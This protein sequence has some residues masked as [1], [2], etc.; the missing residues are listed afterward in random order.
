MNII[1]I[2]I[3]NAQKECW[4]ACSEK[5]KSCKKTGRIS[6]YKIQ[7]LTAIS[8]ISTPT[9]FA[10]PSGGSVVSGTGNIQV[11]DNGKQIS[12]NQNSD[13]IIINWDSFGIRANEKVTFNQPSSNSAAL[14][15]IQGI[16]GSVIM[17]Q[18][19]SNGKVFLINPN[20][21]LFGNGSQVNVGGLTASTQ[22]IT[23][24]DFNNGNNRFS[25]NSRSTIM[26]QGTINS[27]NGSVVLLANQIRN[28]GIINTAN[29]SIV[30]GAGNSFIVN[31]D[32]AGLINIKVDNG[33]IDAL[34][35]N[36]NKLSANGGQVYIAAR[37][38]TNLMKTV[39]NNSGSIEANT[40]N[41][42]AG[43]IVLDAG[44]KDRADVNGVLS[45]SAQG[46]N[47]GN[48]G[49][50][51]ISGK[52]VRVG[53]GAQLNT[54]ANNGITG[55]VTIKADDFEVTASGDT[56]PR[57]D[58]YIAADT[59]SRNLAYSNVS[60][61]NTNSNLAINGPVS[62]TSKNKLELNTPADILINDNIT[63]TGVNSSLALNPESGN[64]TLA[65]GKKITLSG[66]G[67]GFSVK[68]RIY[69]IIQTVDQ[70]QR[71]NSNLYGLYV[72]G[73]N[74]DG[75]NR[76]FESI[77][78]GSNPYSRFEGIL[79]GFGNTITRL[80]IKSTGPN[81][82]LFSSNNGIIKNINL[83]QSTIS[84][85]PSQLT[86]AVGS[87]IGYNTGSLINSSSSISVSASTTSG[88]VNSIGGLVG[89][90]SG[91][92]DRS[93]NSGAVY[94]NTNTR[95]VGGIAGENNSGTI[96]NS[97]NTGSITGS[98]NNNASSSNGAGGLV[99]TNYLGIIDNSQSSG[100]V[101]VY[102]SSNSGGLVGISLGSLI[103]NSSSKGTVRSG[104]YYYYNS[105]INNA[106]GLVGS[107]SDGDII[108]SRSDTTIYGGTST[109]AGGLVGSNL[110]GNISNVVSNTIINNTSG[111]ETGGLV[112]V[113][114]LGTITDAIAT[115]TVAG[116]SNT[117]VGGLVGSNN[118]GNIQDSLVRKV[119]PTGTVSQVSAG[120]NTNIGGAV[121]TNTG[122]IT[123]VAAENN[124]KGG[125]YNKVGG[126]VGLNSGSQM[127][128]TISFSSSYGNVIGGYYSSTGGLVGLNQSQ[129]GESISY[130]TVSSGSYSNLGG[131]AGINESMGNIGQSQVYGTVKYINNQYQTYG[132]L[133]GLNMGL[134]EG[135]LIYGDATRLSPVGINRGTIRN[136]F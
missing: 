33:A 99:G 13:R 131:L 26:N 126:L 46:I 8:V 42:K 97:I 44:T 69:N 77:A 114:N 136:F 65:S 22:N 115:G 81:S 43:K 79:D 112:G 111:R 89:V 30:L 52:H 118:G 122:T 53:L 28:A 29:G 1:F 121:G 84:T 134:L 7:L 15:R 68:N 125:N 74:I 120:S 57:S 91:T 60:I 67:A 4:V 35:Q 23:D 128:G 116:G 113:N 32:G 37:D 58:S 98:M 27:T 25:G 87:I 6:R 55:L 75:L 14:N 100:D 110:A 82:G 50:I 38:S 51:D 45:T 9:A 17:G 20:G 107:L 104:N 127:A 72:L 31:P 124:V 34:V 85:T 90:N 83:T 63:A 39:I 40:L 56:T 24:T 123:G 54:T 41:F 103:R 129:I 80:S 71:I 59:L 18:L 21:V 3:W 76:A 135:N 106:G 86:T 2:R 133:V 5:A 36:T 96:T 48:G 132:G 16:E 11:F 49:S 101:N 19:S 78:S 10:L 62:W 66:S 117:S 108:N 130:S 93:R 109:I 119:T 70:L 92:I 105:G 12:I 94:S 88:Q 95:A 61:T 102:N 64:Y 73:N 47:I